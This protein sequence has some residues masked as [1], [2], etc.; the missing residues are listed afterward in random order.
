MLAIVLQ[1]VEQ[2]FG[3]ADKGRVSA[4]FGIDDRQLGLHV[5]DALEETSGDLVAPDLTRLAT[6][7]ERMIRSGR[8]CWSSPPATRPAHSPPGDDAQGVVFAV[9]GG[10]G[11]LGARKRFAGEL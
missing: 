6:E 4:Q 1:H 11:Y 9:V 5:G 3:C 7:P 2:E 10:L 8:A